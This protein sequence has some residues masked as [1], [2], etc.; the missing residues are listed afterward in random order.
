MSDVRSLSAM[1]A[2]HDEHDEDVLAAYALNAVPPEDRSV[3]EERVQRCVT[4]RGIL[5]DLDESAERL[6]AAVPA[7]RPPPALKARVLAAVADEAER[8][9]EV[10]EP[11]TEAAPAPVLLAQRRWS[12]G[13]WAVPAL[14]VAASVLMIATVALGSVVARQQRE[15]QTE[16]LAGQQLER[17]LADPKR[18]TTAVPVSGG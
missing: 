17:V 9:I 7:H 5:A 14:A 16:R 13:R 4:C 10:A 18:R 2:R 6:A 11:R 1:S 3:L 12:A 8:P 15:L